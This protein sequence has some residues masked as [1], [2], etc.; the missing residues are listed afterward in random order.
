MARTKTT[1]RPRK[2]AKSK[3]PSKRGPWGGANHPAGY[4]VGGTKIATLREVRS[5]AVPTMSLTELTLAQRI[6]LVVASLRLRPGDF[7][8]EM[9]GP[10]AINRARAIAEVR[11]QSRIGRTIMEIELML[12]TTF[13]KPKDQVS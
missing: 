12:L 7:T 3:T 5:P 9:I 6:S 4:H 1:R 13:T 8:I 11:A 10:G 2:V